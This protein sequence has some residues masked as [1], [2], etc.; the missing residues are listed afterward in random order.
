MVGDVHVVR[1]V[2]GHG[3]DHA[4]LVPQVV[5][6]PAATPVL[7]DGAV[8]A[9]R[10][11]GENVAR[12]DVEPLEHRLARP[13]ELLHRV[14]DDD[15]ILNAQ[16]L[17]QRRV[18]ELVNARLVPAQVDRHAVGDLVIECPKQAIAGRHGF[19]AG[20]VGR[21]SWRPFYAP[22]PLAVNRRQGD[23]GPHAAAIHLLQQN[24][25]RPNAPRLRSRG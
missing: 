9:G 11:L 8:E 13:G 1:P 3:P 22:R 18:G 12:I 4:E 21:C 7:P 24:Q 15:L 16:V 2:V 14:H 6:Q 10:G 23:N 17:E 25:C 20:M 5:P 19:A